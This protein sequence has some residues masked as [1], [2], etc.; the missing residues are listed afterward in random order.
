[1]NRFS[2]FNEE[3][4]KKEKEGIIGLTPELKVQYLVQQF[5]MKDQSVLFVCSSL[6]EAN[7][8]YQKFLNYTKSVYFFPM[9]DFLTSEA[10]AISP[11]LKISRLETL[12]KI[13]EEKCIIV[14]NLMGYLRFLPPKEIYK[15]SYITLKMKEPKV[16]ATP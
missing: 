16:F 14:T 13:T 15:N 2:V 10:L 8:Y 7:L 11:E 5:E 1:M 3:E 9:D 4:I 12:K 6:Y